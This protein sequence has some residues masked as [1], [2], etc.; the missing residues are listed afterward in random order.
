M[1]NPLKSAILN[2]AAFASSALVAQGATWDVVNT[3][4]STDT[5]EDNGKKTANMNMKRNHHLKHVGPSGG[6]RSW[7]AVFSAALIIWIANVAPAQNLIQNPGAEAGPGASSF[8]SVVPPTGWIT[9]GNFTACQY[10]IGA[11]T[12]PNPEDSA[13]IGGGTNY[14]A[15]GPSNAFSTARQVIDLS[16]RATGIDA[17]G[18]TATLSGYLGGFLSQNDRMQVVATFRS[19]PDGTGSDLGSMTIG[20]VL[21]ADRA[22]ETK[23][24]FRSANAAIPAGTRSVDILLVANRAEGEYNDAFADNLSFEVSGDE[25]GACVP[26][27]SDLTAWYRGEGDASDAQGGSTG[28]PKNGT[29][30]APGKVGQAFSFDGVDDFVEIPHNRG[31]N[32]PPRITLT[33]WIKPDSVKAGSRII[34]KD[35]SATTCAPPTVN[36]SLEVRGLQGNKA[37]F[38]F[39]TGDKVLHE[40]VGTSVI[41]TGVFTHVAASYDG[42]TAKIYVNGVLENSLVVSGTSLAKSNAPTIIG[43]GGAGCR[44]SNGGQIEFDGLIDEVQIYNRALTDAEISAIVNSGNGGICGAPRTTW[45]AGRD[46]RVNER[47]DHAAEV[48]PTN[49]KVPEWSYGTRAQAAATE[50]TLFRPELHANRSDGLE[51]WISSGGVEGVVAVNVKSTPVII[52]SGVQGLLPQQLDLHPTA[53]NRSI[54]ARWTAPKDGDYRMAAKWFDL[55]TRNGDGVSAHLVINGQEKFVQLMPDGGKA[56]L[57]VGPASTF[58]LKAGDLVDFVVGPRGNYFSDSTAFNA[59]IAPVPHVVVNAPT[60]VNAGEDVPVT[61]TVQHPY[62][63]ISS[64]ELRVNGK[65]ALGPDA[66]APYEFTIPKEQIDSPVLAI[67]ALATDKNGAQGLSA[68]VQVT[69]Q[70]P[71]SG[72]PMATRAA[73]FLS[74][75]G[76]AGP[77]DCV[78][79]VIGEILAAFDFIFTAESGD[80]HDPNNWLS[81]TPGQIPGPFDD[82]LIGDSTVTVNNTANA[83]RVY[84]IGLES[85]IVGGL[86]EPEIHIFKELSMEK[87]TLS[88]I[89]LLVDRKAKVRLTE[90]SNFSNV[91]IE[92]RG[93]LQFT[94]T[95]RFPITDT[96][97]V[98]RGTMI[99]ETPPVTAKGPELHLAGF[100]NLGGLR[101]TP[102]SRLGIP[103]GAKFSGSTAGGTLPGLKPGFEPPKLIGNDGSTMVAAGSLNLIGNDGS[104]LIGNDGST[105]APIN[106]AELIGND[107]S[108]IA[109]A[110]GP[111]APSKQEKGQHAAQSPAASGIILE[112]GTFSGNFVIVGDVLNQAAFISPGD[113]AGG[114]FISGNYTQKSAATLVLEIG[115]TATDPLQ[116]DIFQATGTATLGGNLVV[117]TIDDYTPSQTDGLSPLRFASSSGNFASISSN[118]QVTIGANGAQ[119]NVTGPNPPAPKA[120]NIA[121]RMKV[122]TGDN[123]LIAGFIIT[124][125]QPKKVIIRGIGP[126]LPFPGILADPTLSLD[127]GALTNDNW[128]STQEQEIIDTTIPP[129]NN[130]ESAIVATLSPG[131]HTAILRG[132]GSSTG[133]GVIEVYDLESGSPVQLANIS[134]RGFVQSGDNVMIGGFIIGGTYPA[135]VIVRAIGPSLPFAGKLAN[136]TLELVNQ[137]G[138]SISNDNWRETQEADITATT[139]PPTQENEAAIVATLAPGA[140]T[141]VVRGADDTTGIAVVEAYNLS[142]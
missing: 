88:D 38:F 32:N 24:V 92:Q 128:R 119:I 117:T 75:R 89:N 62:L 115:G 95:G 28:T 42:S 139:I 98:N 61:V 37:D 2:P 85:R 22:S 8:P 46:L 71:E 47:P 17:G 108:T 41:P 53:D 103:P 81:R 34:S 16:G 68:P 33:A 99:I 134:S 102:G 63:Q 26:P 11:A 25:P 83:G 78:F 1:K 14:F 132:T 6:I 52:E 69:I 135:K 15:G 43:S 106:P 130:L 57:P 31:R 111:A 79:C 77:Q 100:E 138:G 21:P 120:L 58:S 44:A 112:G 121:T 55:D 142:Q 136:P 122:E 40:L 29:E 131:A 39:T 56:E 110:G 19:A 74:T 101:Q 141:A 82:V 4:A 35:S 49:T 5:A 50:L 20:P 97:I 123:A 18:L 76:A 87:G 65:G 90:K 51:G 66:T 59:V 107:G 9:S 126:S 64:V 27:P 67:E 73:K 12:D 105:L 137:N 23:L 125:A 109:P 129:S 124:G 48:N 116:Y 96:R 93:E 113:S 118:A 60:K 94:G 140:Y 3:F 36:Y 133:I 7:A 80:W 72:A 114:I 30:F 104:T 10:A 70:K 45:G 127:N 54:V 91:F 13:A 84:V 86:G